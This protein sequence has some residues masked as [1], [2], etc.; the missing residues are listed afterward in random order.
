MHAKTNTIGY[1]TTNPHLLTLVL[2]ICIAVTL[3]LLICLGL[4]K[5]LS[6]CGL[7]NPTHHKE[8]HTHTFGQVKRSRYSN[9]TVTY[10]NRTVESS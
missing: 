1:L 7:E 8:S 10:S 2:S 5:V 3:S 6:P 9:K 4:F